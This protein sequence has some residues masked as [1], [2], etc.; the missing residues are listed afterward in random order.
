[1]ISRVRGLLSPFLDFARGESQA[2]LLLILAAIAAFVWANSAYAP[3]YHAMKELHV[4]LAFG[5]WHLDKEL[6]HWVDDGLMAA[7]FLLVG[8]EIKREVLVGELSDPRAAALPVVAAAGGMIVPALIYAA[9]AWGQSPASRGWGVPMATDIAFA[10]GVLAL[11]GDRVPVSLKVFLTALAI[12]DDLGAIAVIALFYAGDIALGK[13]AISLLLWLGALLYGARGGYRLSVYGV[14]GIGM[15]YFMQASGVHATVAGVLLALAVPMKRRIDGGTLRGDLEKLL[16][17]H[18]FEEQQVV[19]EDLE[20]LLERGQS[21]LHRLEH[22]LNPVNAYL[23]MPVFALF[24]AGFA[25]GGGSLGATISLGAFLGLLLGKPIGV[26]GAS[27]LSIRTGIASRPRGV[28]WTALAGAGVL[29]GIGF[30]MALFIAG[31]AFTDPGHLDQAKLGVISASILAAVLG[32][33]LL[34]MAGRPSEAV[35]APAG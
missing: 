24:N 9:V 5:G 27:W 3:A 32:G 20:D 34:V 33:A 6:I 22:M 12:V 8:L 35:E 1:M 19:A 26:V 18:D 13:L 23:I 29:A 21:P 25:L 4:G 28:S 7:F 14:L 16:S 30:T 17:S 10:L 2:G 15:W 31:L 11:L